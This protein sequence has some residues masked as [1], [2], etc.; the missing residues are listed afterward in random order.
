MNKYQRIF[1]L[2]I[3]LF[4]LNIAGSAQRAPVPI[5]VGD[6]LEVEVMPS[7][8]ESAFENGT[9]VIFELTEPTYI[10]LIA[11]ALEND[12]ITDPVFTLL[13]ENRE[14]ITVPANPYATIARQP[15]DA[16]LEDNL[17]MPG[18]YTLLLSRADEEGSGIVE[19]GVLQGN[20]DFLG[21]GDITVID[22]KIDEFERF[23]LTVPFQAGEIVSL[24][25]VSPDSENIDLRIAV[26]D[27]E[28]NTVA[29][30]DDHDTLEIFLGDFDPK[31]DRWNV[32]KDDEYRILVRG[33]N[34]T[35]AGPFDLY[36]TRYG[37]LDTTNAGIEQ[38]TLETRDRE[39]HTFEFEGSRG[40]LVN[41]TARAIEDSFVDPQITI[42]S[43]ESI[44]VA[45]NDDHSTDNADLDTF[46]ASLQRIMLEEDGTFIL[47]VTSVSGSGS[48]EVTFERLGIFEAREFPEI[49][50][51]RVEIQT[52][53]PD[54]GN[55]EIAPEVTAEPES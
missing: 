21:M 9:P 28:G 26:R 24:A 45:E 43:P 33:F 1:L 52:I 40:E 25:A 29:N 12:P 2:T 36:I 11:R 17:L 38:W 14:L 44:I 3:L 54:T 10:T 53:E 7:T 35:D 47:E 39:R 51:T 13:E 48:V 50:R 18:R 42:V 20:A 4:A 6:I 19:V 15:N 8:A 41:I 31:I 55:E 5:N 30:N 27:S 49:D 22:S 32:L 34:P 37:L 16:I 23:L 46:D